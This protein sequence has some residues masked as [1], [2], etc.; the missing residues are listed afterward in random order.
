MGIVQRQNVA[1]CSATYQEIPSE[2]ESIIMEM[3]C[4][5]ARFLRFPL[6]TLLCVVGIQREAKN[7]IEKDI[8]IVILK[9]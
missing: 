5:I 7:I 3:E 8:L 1:L 9:L 6:P 2:L 4:L